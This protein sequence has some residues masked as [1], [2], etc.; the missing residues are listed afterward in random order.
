MTAYILS[1]DECNKEQH[2]RV[3]GKCA[4]LGTMTQAGV[5]VPPG[6]AITTDAY[7]ALL[8]QE[9]LGERIAAE[10]DQLTV[11]DDKA[12]DEVSQRVRRLIEESV[13]AADITTAIRNAYQA[14]CERC[15]LDAVPVAVRSSATA[16]DLPGASFAGQ[17]DAYLWIIGAEDVLRHVQKCWASLFTARAIAYRLDNG[18]PHHEVQMSVGV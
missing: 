4:S 15:Q 6:F 13:I 10:L 3:G 17:Q 2:H 16:E 5:P 1:F 12:L 9:G 18:F 7:H 11:S 8:A 14:L